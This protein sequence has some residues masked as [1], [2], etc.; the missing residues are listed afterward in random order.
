MT[1]QAPPRRW[2]SPAEAAEL[3]GVSKT[4]AQAIA[5]RGEF[6]TA[7]MHGARLLSADEVFAALR[8]AGWDPAMGMTAPELMTTADAAVLIGCSMGRVR[9]LADSGLIRS[10]RL[11][12]GVRRLNAGD[13]RSQARAGIGGCAQ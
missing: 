13:V 10:F 9:R 11:P 5:A 1:T 4:C 8:Q 12:T 2:L 6:G 7:Y 3:L